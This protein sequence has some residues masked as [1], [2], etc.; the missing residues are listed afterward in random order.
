MANCDAGNNTL[1]P[2][3]SLI[4]GI[5][6]TVTTLES[7]ADFIIPLVDAFDLVVASITEPTLPSAMTLALNKFTADAICAASTDL[8]PINDFVA[9]CLTEA[10]SAVKRYLRNIYSNIDDGIDLIT[11]LV[12]LPEYGLFKYYQ[13]IN[14]LADNIKDLITAIDNRIECISDESYDDQIDAITTRVN[15]VIDYLRL[16]SDG[17]FDADTFLADLS[18]D[19]QT[20]MK[21]YAT[22]AANLKTEI[23]ANI[24]STVD[25]TA[26]V[27]PKRFY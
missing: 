6:K 2:Y 15:D 5:N 13:K 20:N 7:Q 16:E 11:D 21:A 26:S 23:E 9:D 14:G 4:D 8:Q 24:S 12:T 3:Q 17:S 27:L 18:G 19:L 25:L 22:K 10:M 1:D